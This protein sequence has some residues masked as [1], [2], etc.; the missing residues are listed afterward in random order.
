MPIATHTVLVRPIAV[1]AAAGGALV[2]WSGTPIANKIAVASID[3]ATAG[4]LRSMLAGLLAGSF[5]LALRLPFPSIPRQRLLLLL[6]GI[7]N[8]AVWP[9]LLSIGLGLTT[10]NH[11]A[12]IIAMIPI[13]TG[14]IAAAADRSW[15]HLLW[16]AGGAL[17][18]AGTF[19][20]IFY[21]GS[22]PGEV[23]G[24]SV[25]GDLVIL[26]GVIACAL[27][28]VAGG[29]LS[30]VI[31]TWATTFWGLGGAAVVLVP[32]VGMLAPRTDWAAVGAAGWLSIAYMTLLSSFA[33]YLAW[34]WA[35]G[36][37]GIARMSSWQLSQPAVTLVFAALLLG[38]AITLPLLVSG[39]AIL[40]GA[41]L[42]QL[43]GRR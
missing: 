1:Y 15:P 5:A 2:L 18:V 40:A 17:A 7:G 9:L 30:P 25:T 10:A 28:Y 23:A 37:G 14:L 29:K 11:A 43:P 8:F 20:L 4:I 12:F 33:G 38:E 6:S 19:M 35:L 41:W 31:G 22:G 26:V 21:R 32:V 34:F 39:A 3:P 36:H 27:G 16:W 13:A 24:A 42:A